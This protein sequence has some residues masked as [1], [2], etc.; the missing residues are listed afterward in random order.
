MK[1]PSPIGPGAPGAPQ[2]LGQY[3]V[4]NHGQ[5]ATRRFLRLNPE[6]TALSLNGGWWEAQ[7]RSFAR[8]GGERGRRDCGLGERWRRV[9]RELTGR[10]QEVLG[11]SR[12]RASGPE[13]AFEG[14]K[15]VVGLFVS[16]QGRPEPP[17]FL[18]MPPLAGRQLA[19]GQLPPAL[20]CF[21]SLPTQDGRTLGLI[22]PYSI[23]APVPTTPGA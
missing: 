8:P 2:P 23:T 14:D 13:V 3:Q 22:S 1:R 11:C 17:W 12:K 19:P 7:S 16:E 10:E 21:P 9:A 18:L 20:H 4:A 15:R 6:A 5:A